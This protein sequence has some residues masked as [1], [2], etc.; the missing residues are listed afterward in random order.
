MVI[1]P[2]LTETIIVSKNTGIYEI[3]FIFKVAFTEMEININKEK[4]V[5]YRIEN[6]YNL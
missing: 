1:K 4:I 6:K 2:T 5:K 3:F